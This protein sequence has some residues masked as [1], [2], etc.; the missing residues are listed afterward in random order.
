MPA[1]E[2][3]SGGHT[4][5]AAAVPTERARRKAPPKCC[6]ILC[7][8][9]EDG[10][11]CVGSSR[12]TVHAWSPLAGRVPSFLSPVC[13]RVAQARLAA[14][15]TPRVRARGTPESTALQAYMQVHATCILYRADL[16]H[17]QVTSLHASLGHLLQRGGGGV[18]SRR[19]SRA[20]VWRCG[21]WPVLAGLSPR[22]RFRTAILTYFTHAYYM[23]LQR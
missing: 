17:N 18:A 12:I 9:G 8:K 4:F 14:P 5:C 6:C 10:L 19:L 20:V 21:L 23:N 22:V 13:S 15:T 3:C 16:N 11:A 2:H 7:K 1:P